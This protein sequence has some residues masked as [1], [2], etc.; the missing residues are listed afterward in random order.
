MQIINRIGLIVVFN[1]YPITSCSMC[2]TSNPSYSAKQGLKA[3]GI[4]RRYKILSRRLQKH[5]YIYSTAITYTT[6]SKPFLSEALFVHILT[7]K[8]GVGFGSSLE[9][10]SLILQQ[11]HLNMSGKLFKTFFSLFPLFRSS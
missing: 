6:D 11:G 2:L 4:Q 1:A 7:N 8:I 3:P 10:K 9:R 5:R